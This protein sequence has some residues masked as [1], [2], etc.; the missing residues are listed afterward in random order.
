ML[1]NKKNPHPN[2]RMARD[3]VVARRQ[4]EG[5]EGEG[6]GL[7]GGDGQVVVADAERVRAVD[8]VDLE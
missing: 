4:D 2:V 8:G 7:P 5:G 1:R 3:L 6:K